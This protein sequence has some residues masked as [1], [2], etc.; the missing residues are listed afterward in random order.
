MTENTLDFEFVSYFYITCFY[1]DEEILQLFKSDLA[2]Q[3]ND[4]DPG[5]TLISHKEI[6]SFNYR[7]FNYLGFIQIDLKRLTLP[8]PEPRVILQMSQTIEEFCEKFNAKFPEKI[9]LDRINPPYMV[10]IGIKAS[11]SGET[12]PIAIEWSKENIL[13]YKKSLGTWIEVYSGQWPDYSDELYLS[14]IQNN[15]SNRLSE[16][17]FIRTNSAFI[18]MPEEGFDKYMPYMKINFIE[19]ILRVR[20][21]LFCYFILNNEIDE[22]SRRFSQLKMSLPAI[23]NEIGQVED[24]E[25]LIEKLASRVFNERIINR[26]AHSKKVLNTCYTLFQIELTLTTI[27][28]KINNLQSSFNSVREKHKGSMASRQTLWISILTILTGSQVVF[29]S[30]EKLLEI[31][32]IAET[33]PTA[34]LIDTILWVIIGIVVIIAVGSLIW[35]FLNTKFDLRKLKMQ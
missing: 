14:R 17:H 23:E 19:Q 3:L 29:A 32:G 26:R 12:T 13:K 33:D 7:K 16:V 4:S 9:L 21:L 35:T 1:Q 10:N 6:N 25:R 34:E 11:R 8:A 27:Q 22:F 5:I 30:K 18:F 15:I 20:A 31:L 28:E 2:S 24:L